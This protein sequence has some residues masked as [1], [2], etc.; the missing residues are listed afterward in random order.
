MTNAATV[1]L[2]PNCY[3]MMGRALGILPQGVKGV[4]V[5]MKM[6]FEDFLCWFTLPVEVLLRR[7]IGVRALTLFH[8]APLVIGSLAYTFLFRG[9]SLDPLFSIF[10][11]SSAGFAVY[12]IRESR[13]WEANGSPWRHTYSNGTPLPVWD[14]LKQFLETA[15]LD[16]TRYLTPQKVVRFYEPMLCLLVGIPFLLTFSKFLGGFLIAASVALLFKAH[17]RHLRFVD[18]M[19]DRND[20]MLTGQILAEMPNRVEGTKKPLPFVAEVALH[21]EQPTRKQDDIPEAQIVTA[22][23]TPPA[24]RIHVRCGGCRTKLRAKLGAAGHDCVCPKC[25]APVRVPLK[26]AG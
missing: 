7:H 25:S 3:T 11:L 18:V 8:L 12:H 26:V 13:V 1:E 4:F 15:G 5:V 23:A 10:A 17:I 6:L 24:P 19:R 22:K 20:A 21:L 9:W 14:R 2:H 16:P